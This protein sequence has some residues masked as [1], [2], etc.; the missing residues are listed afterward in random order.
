MSKAKKIN[1]KWFK[2]EH[3]KDPEAKKKFEEYVLGS[4]LLLERLLEICE[5]EIKNVD[6]SRE[7]EYDKPN[8]D[9]RQAHKNG[10][11]EAF[12]KIKKLC[13]HIKN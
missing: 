8:W 12:Q 4:G 11:R 3:N 6:T 13:D 7:I 9:Y 2:E 5:S 10:V 1:S